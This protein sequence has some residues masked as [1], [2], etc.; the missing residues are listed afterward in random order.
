[1][2]YPGFW[3]RGAGEGQ[4]GIWSCLQVQERGLVQ[5]WPTDTSK[6]LSKRKKTQMGCPNIIN[7]NQIYVNKQVF[8]KMH[9]ILGWLER[10]PNR[11]MEATGAKRCWKDTANSVMESFINLQQKVAAKNVPKN[12]RRQSH[13]KTLKHFQCSHNKSAKLRQNAIALL[14][15]LKVLV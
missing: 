15:L 9:Y 5:L 12:M 4:E 3:W 10:I 6:Y 13:Y 1:M 11:N 7:D 14:L 8:L 2:F